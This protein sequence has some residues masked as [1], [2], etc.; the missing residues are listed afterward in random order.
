[1]MIFIL[2]VVHPSGISLTVEDNFGDFQGI[3]RA[4]LIFVNLN[5]DQ[6]STN[7]IVSS[8]IIMLQIGSIRVIR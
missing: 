7:W 1:M 2:M 4:T 6:N 3:L 8:I 5:M